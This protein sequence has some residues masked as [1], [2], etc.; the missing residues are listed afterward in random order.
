LRWSSG[1]QEAPDSACRQPVTAR[2][3]WTSGY[4]SQDVHK[5]HRSG[6][7][8]ELGARW[9]LARPGLV[10]TIWTLQSATRGLACT[11]WTGGRP[12]GPA[13]TEHRNLLT[14]GPLGLVSTARHWWYSCGLNAYYIDGLAVLGLL[15]RREVR[16]SSVTRIACVDWGMSSSTDGALS[17]LMSAW[18]LWNLDDDQQ[19]RQRLSL[20][21]AL[22]LE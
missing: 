9:V 4:S 15:P 13:R 14:F 6:D 5:R 2:S 19:L 20:P 18:L 17:C 16:W 1:M 22:F 10:S 11:A 12:A 7:G 3:S 8:V 21:A